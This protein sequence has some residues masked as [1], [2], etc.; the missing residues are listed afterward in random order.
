[1]DDLSER[2]SN[3][4]VLKAM[5]LAFHNER[6]D[7]IDSQID[8]VIRLYLTADVKRGEEPL[9]NA[10]S[11][12]SNYLRMIMRRKLANP[13]FILS[14]V[15]KWARA[16]HDNK[17]P[18]GLLI[19]GMVIREGAN[20]NVYLTFPEKGNLHVLA[21]MSAARGPADPLYQYMFSECWDRISTVQL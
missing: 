1:M 4:D 11:I 6:R 5:N 8:A 10:F 18:I 12:F 7:K 2:E 21:W 3:T 14:S 13:N 15:I 17:N 19:L 16:G 9:S 20:P